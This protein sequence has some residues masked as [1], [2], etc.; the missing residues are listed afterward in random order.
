MAFVSV[1]PHHGAEHSFKVDIL[2][3]PA[4]GA[5]PKRTWRLANTNY[6]HSWLNTTLHKKIP[7]AR[8]L[9]YDH[10]NEEER[11]L[12]IKVGYEENREEHKSAAKKYASAEAALE[13]YSV[14]DWAGRFI[15]ALKVIRRAH[16]DRPMLFICHSTGGIV[17]KQALSKLVH[18]EQINL[19]AVCIGVAFF[20][21]PH[22]GSNV[23][24]GHEYVHAIKECLGL[25][26]EM[27]ARLRQD[28]SL[29]NSFLEKL[30]YLFTDAAFGVKVYSYYETRETDLEVLVTGDTEGETLTNVSLCV[31]DDRSARLSTTDLSIE[32]ESVVELNTT[33]TGTP[34]FTTDT[35]TP[36]FTNQDG[37]H[38]FINIIDTLIHNFSVDECNAYQK[39]NSSIMTEVIVDIHQFYQTRKPASIKVWPAKSSLKDFFHDGPTK[40]LD[41][42]IGAGKS[43]NKAMTDEIVKPVIEIERAT[44]SI[45]VVPADSFEDATPP[46]Q[47]PMPGLST[48]KSEIYKNVHTRRPP[49]DNNFLSHKNS[50]HLAPAKD[51]ANS[52]KAPVSDAI[53]E[54]VPQ[55]APTY[56]IPTSS[57]DLFKWIHIPFTHSGW[58]PRVLTTISKEKADVDLHT[59]LMMDQI[60]MSQHN[61]SRHFSPHARFVRSA[62]RYL[63]PKENS[64]DRLDGHLTP[65][66][67]I[68]EPQFVIYL[69]YLHWDT[70]QNMNMRAKT[71]DK[72]RKQTHSRPI[73]HGIATGA[74]IESKLIW[75]YLQSERPVHCR[76]TL[77][78]Y[79]YP[80]LH[81]TAVRDGDQIL[82]KRTKP[83]AKTAQPKEPMR[84]QERHSNRLAS[85]GEP[86]PPLDDVIAKVL[87]VDQLWLWILNNETVITFA[88]PKE[89]EDSDGEVWK[90]GDLRTNI[91][92]D[93]S[94]DYAR[95]CH[96]P[97]DF[98]A[99]VV[100]HAIKT[101]LENTTDRNLQV[102]RIFEEYISILTERQTTSFKDFRNFQTYQSSKDI[103]VNRLPRYVDNRGDLD[104]LLELRD[105]QDELN[106][107][108][109]LFA[110]QASSVHEMLEKYQPLHGQQTGKNGIK[111]LIEAKRTLGDYIGQTLS[112]LKSAEAA[113]GAFK[114]LLDM[115]QKQAN[116]VEAHLAREHAEVAAD[117]SRS[118]MIFTIFTI[119]FLPLSFFASVFGINVREWSGTS[120][121]PS[122][123]SVFVYMGSIS[124]AV[125]VVALL[126]AFNRPFRKAVQ[127]SWKWLGGK[128]FSGRKHKLGSEDVA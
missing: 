2:G 122:L 79:G 40:C 7:S 42:S 94:G 109:K 106:T 36:N 100:L 51:R 46:V 104:D 95:Q 98:A 121:N 81:N 73:D 126:L 15:E 84:R 114:D 63:P 124:V 6:E 39:L 77:D 78:Q 64:D 20:A 57:S 23:L 1:H 12:E 128:V 74:S 8:I 89:E 66:S 43:G 37:I 101:L 87:M 17:V 113:E 76:R 97:F 19:A 22:N 125:I 5:D 69:P 111:F 102:F 88:A 49:L 27:S 61:R 67:A 38:G 70:F 32:D 44:P 45:E 91:Y 11:S 34:N 21:T 14:E 112:M 103:D 31:V 24:S 127:G 35:G 75:Q 107:M 55:R 85:S 60:W 25:K 62:V 59:K 30:N 83:E 54:G 50:S 10:L 9:L 72:R 52:V 120:S 53:Q 41:K 33:H 82:Y 115:K 90:Q 117:Q 56:Q 86:Q 26:W 68:D 18:R 96:D 71:V 65:S 105:I 4:I 13:I 80:S 116:I 29:K 123:H 108:R 47:K 99:L 16:T 3:V 118:V 48:P 58:V 110:E 92:K 28:F 93:I 119:I